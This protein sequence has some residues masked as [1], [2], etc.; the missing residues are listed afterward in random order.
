[1]GGGGSGL[2]GGGE[3]VEGIVKPYIIDYRSVIYDPDHARFPRLSPTAITT[4]LNLHLDLN[5]LTPHHF[6]SSP[7]SPTSPYS[8]HSPHSPSTH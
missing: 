4:I 8:P 5:P 2:I 1:M 3:C 7:P 6:P